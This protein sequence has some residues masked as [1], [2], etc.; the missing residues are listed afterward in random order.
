MLRKTP[1]IILLLI[2]F[3]SPFGLACQE[4]ATIVKVNDGDTV[5]LRYRGTTEHVRLIGIDAPESYGN[6]RA[7]RESNRTGRSLES[8]IA[9]GKRSSAYL[10]DLLPIGSQV[11][12]EFDVEK[13]DRY[14]RL[15]AYLYLKDGAF[16][17]E[18]ILIDGFARPYTVPPNVRY[19][20]RF[21]KAADKARNSNSGLWQFQADP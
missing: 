17:N 1:L 9:L 8:I 5:V 3:L 13:R 7:H 12:L 18:K 15:L 21:Q 2:Q 4:L 11:S 6:E 14:Q 10:K 19:A 16:L 20:K